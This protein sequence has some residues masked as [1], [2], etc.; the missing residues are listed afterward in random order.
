MDGSYSRV[1]AGVN[2]ARPAAG[3]GRDIG[4]WWRLMRRDVYRD[5]TDP[6]GLGAGGRRGGL[7]DV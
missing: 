7:G 3:L 2:D 4:R 1:V 6:G 5:E